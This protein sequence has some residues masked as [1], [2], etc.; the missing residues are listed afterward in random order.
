MLKSMTGTLK[1][2]VISEE[3]RKFLA[4]LLTQLTDQQLRDLFEV[5]RFGRRS[6]P[7]QPAA[8]IDQWV[9]AFKKKRTE[10]VSH[11]CPN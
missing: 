3:G 6:L 7:D 11:S 2:P 8:T 4:G 10:I 1:D 9:A 5:A